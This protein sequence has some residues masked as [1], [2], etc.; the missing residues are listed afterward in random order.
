[1]SLKKYLK[2]QG[3]SPEDVSVREEQ[4]KEVERGVATKKLEKE[5]PLCRWG[6]MF[7]TDLKAGLSNIYQSLIEGGHFAAAVWASPGQDTLIARTMNIIMKETNSLSP[8]PGTPG[9][10][11]LSDENSLKNSFMMSGFKDLTIDR[12]NVSFDFDSP[13]DFTAFTNETA[14]PLQK[15]LANQTNERKGEILEAVTEAARIYFDKNG[16]KSGSK[17]KLYL[18]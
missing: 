10:F 2:V 7:L 17:M 18:F 14:G 5:K 13:E 11:S 16:G 8:P 4:G 6:L 1:M 9:P 15:I 3:S 12:M